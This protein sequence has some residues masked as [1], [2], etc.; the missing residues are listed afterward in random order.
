MED[1][2]QVV[3]HNKREILWK[4]GDKYLVFLNDENQ[5]LL[6]LQFSISLYDR[7]LLQRI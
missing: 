6:L 4:N 7:P 2:A 5:E 1:P 3:T